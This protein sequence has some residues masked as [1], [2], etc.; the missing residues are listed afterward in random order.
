M[1]NEFSIQIRPN[2]YVTRVE[3]AQLLFL[4]NDYLAKNFPKCDAILQDTSED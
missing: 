3:W 4:L 1:K 2:E